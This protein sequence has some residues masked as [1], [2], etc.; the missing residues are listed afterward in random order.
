MTQALTIPGTALVRLP[1]PRTLQPRPS[2]FG[3][4]RLR[5][6]GKLGVQSAT[7]TS[8]TARLV[9]TTTGSSLLSV[10]AFTGPAAPFVAAAG[11][12]LELGGVITGMFGGCGQTCVQATQIVNQAAPILQQNL[13]TYFALPIP[14]SA[15]SQAQ[16]VQN[17]QQVWQSVVNACATPAL[18]DAGQRCVAD[19]MS[20]GLTIQTPTG[21]I[22]GNGKFPWD[23]YYLLPILN[24]SNVEQLPPDAAAGG[25]PAAQ[26]GGMLA[27]ASPLVPLLAL[28]GLAFWAF[29]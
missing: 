29:S 27:S 23:Q 11:A 1:M 2:V 16:A 18:Q 8:A 9:L 28:A 12:L 13:D 3:P 17:F 5:G 14:R 10:S 26:S 22:T 20:A 19:R 15:A 7:G 4:T 25:S 6:L 24:D 21:P